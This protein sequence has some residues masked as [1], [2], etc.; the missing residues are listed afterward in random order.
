MA[1]LETIRSELDKGR[2]QHEKLL[3]DDPIFEEIT[4]LFGDRIGKASTSEELDQLYSD[5]RL[6]YE[7]RTP[8]GYEDINKPEPE[9]FGDYVGWRQILNYS[10]KEHCSLILVTDDLKEDW[11][12]IHGDRRIGPRPE[13]VA[14]YVNTCKKPFYMYTL[15]QFTRFAQD[16]LGSRLGR[17]A[18]EEIRW[19]SAVS[20]RMLT[21]KQPQAG[22]SGGV[23]NHAE[24]SVSFEK[25]DFEA[26]EHQDLD[27]PK[28]RG[29]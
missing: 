23:D 17:A 18:L 8:P 5:A 1:A 28:A 13:L 20:V 12:Q 9:R 11:W 4:N 22:Q 10:T 16:R 26:M 24:K 3:S 15:E 29:S 14:E 27:A 6:R 21:L 2:K 25:G 7:M 19:R